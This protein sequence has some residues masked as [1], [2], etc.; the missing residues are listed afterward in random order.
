MNYRSEIDGLRA[1]AIIPIIFFHFNFE[2]FSG[3]FVGVDIFFVISG[4]LITSIILTDI[5]QNKF[6][7]FNFYHRRAR[8]ILPALF[9]M[10]FICIPLAMVILLPED[11]KEFSN[12]LIAITLFI[13]NIFF[14][15]NSD[16]FDTSAELSP[17]LH[18]W[19]L[20]VE[21]QFYFIFPLIFIFFLKRSKFL[22]LIITLMLFL[23]SLCVSEYAANVHPTAAFFLLP[24]RG[25]E[26]LMGVL[27]ALCLSQENFINL[28]RTYR[29]IASLFGLGLIIFAVF[30]FSKSTTFPGFNALI[31]TIG[32][33]LIILSANKCTLVGKLLSTKIFVG[34]GLL[35]YGAYLWHQ[36]LLAFSRYKNTGNLD[37]YSYIL[38]FLG[39]FLIA[40]FSW[41]IIEMPFR[42]NKI[43]QTKN[44]ILIS[45]L[46][47][48]F[49]ITFAII[50]ITKNGFESRLDQNQRNL[51]S[52]N[53]YNYKEIYSQDKCFLNRSQSYKDFNKFCKSEN[54]KDSIFIWG[55]SHAAALSFGLRKNFKNVSQYTTSA[56]PPI[57]SNNS[58]LKSSCKKINEFI[59]EMVIQQQPNILILHSNWLLYDEKSLLTGLVELI[60]FIHVN[61]PYTNI[62]VLG[63]VPQF[64][65]SLP[66]YIIL[67]KNPFTDD[68][69]LKS[70][71]TDKILLIDQKLKDLSKENNIVFF[72]AIDSF[73]DGLNCLVTYPYGEVLMPMAWDYGHLTAAGSIF[74]SEKLKP[75]LIN[76]L[77]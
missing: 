77:R 6:S 55:D 59:S 71:H 40:Y 51:L 4:Y 30:F 12:S 57:L 48:F 8:R 44:F 25:W 37:N 65:P 63:G 69:R 47:L 29:E 22:L 76:L 42:N 26:L 32:T 7:I 54:L 58:K 24:F 72:S 18:T 21:E 20:A 75:N 10:L 15:R 13:S 34:I 41:K 66:S 35:S 60:K 33:S 28:K 45:T 19:S 43:K 31:P 3:G 68:L 49:L 39:T 67:N 38:I 5:N 73:C 23:A 27:T 50:C 56:C 62:I 46:V 70:S 61:S 36:P 14:W 16:Y 17:L 9:L 11:L 2:V 1:L 74:L 64:I 53:S 52:F